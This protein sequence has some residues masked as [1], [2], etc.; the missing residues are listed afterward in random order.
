MITSKK[1]SKKD[2]EAVARACKCSVMTVYRVKKGD[3]S[4]VSHIKVRSCLD[5]RQKQLDEAALFAA[6]MEKEITDYANNIKIEHH[7]K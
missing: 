1:L 4:T 7:G 6:R 2:V 3:Y 5:F